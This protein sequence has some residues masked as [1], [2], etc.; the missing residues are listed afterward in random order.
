M[1]KYEALY[2]IANR[3]AT[4]GCVGTPN[5]CIGGLEDI[6]VVGT[7]YAEDQAVGPLVDAEGT[8][9]INVAD[10]AT[11]ATAVNEKAVEAIADAKIAEAT[12]QMPTEQMPRK[13]TKKHL[14][15]RLQ[16][17]Q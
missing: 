2:S 15:A 11:S 7:K 14:P 17:C 5:F 13:T 3:Q 1:R 9:D 6:K 4:A 8:D 16:S 10:L 12:E